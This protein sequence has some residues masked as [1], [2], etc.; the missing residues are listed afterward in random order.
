[1]QFALV[2]GQRT[3][4]QKGLK[5]TCPV[6]DQAVI[7][8][9][10]TIREPHW[11]HKN[12]SECDHW[13]EPE[14]DW[15]RAWKSQFPKEWHEYLHRAPDGE[16]HIADVKTPQGWAI[17]FQHSHIKPEERQSRDDF[18]SPL[19]WVVDG[20]TRTK[21]QA[22]FYG[23]LNSGEQIGAELVK[24]FTKGSAL[25]RDW[26]SCRWPVFFDFG[27]D[28]DLWW[29]IKGSPDG[30]TYLSSLSHD[31][32]VRFLGEVPPDALDVFKLLWKQRLARVADHEA[33]PIHS[34]PPVQSNIAQRGPRNPL[35]P[36][37]YRRRRL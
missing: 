33:P 28:D 2:D 18:Y 30:P 23:V 13:W 25:L 29:L 7:A 27:K 11:S 15:H 10:G 37:I 21:D 3:E 35:A 8:R 16:K 26:E 12:L 6:C 36:P 20:K 34:V 17:E 22:Q 4:A 14:T 24:T 9:C 32:F 5:G 1:M 31:D 19:V